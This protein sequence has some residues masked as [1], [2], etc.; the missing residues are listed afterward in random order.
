MYLKRVYIENNGAIE[1]VD[2][3]L[4]FTNQGAPKPVVL[5]GLNGSGK[6]NFLS[7][8]VDALFEGSA[9]YHRDI[10]PQDG[11]RRSFFRVAGGPNTRT[12]TRGSFTVLKFEHNGQEFMFREKVILDETDNYLANL[13]S[14]LSGLENWHVDGAHKEFS[15]SEV[16]AKNIFESN[17]HLYFPADRSEIPYWMN[18]SAVDEQWIHTT[19]TA[20]GYLKNPIYVNKSLDKLSQWIL[21]LIIDSRGGAYKNALGVVTVDEWNYK[22]IIEPSNNILRICDEILKLIMDDDEV[23]FAYGSRN[24][25]YKLCVAKNKQRFLASIQSLSAGQS[26]LL[27]IFGTLV[28]QH[29]QSNNE[30]GLDIDKVTGICIIDEADVNLH[31]DLQ[32]NVLPK[33]MSLFPN[34]Q[35]II[36]THSP[37]ILTGLNKLYGEDGL[38]IIDMPSGTEIGVDAY[39]EFTNALNV[40]KNTRKFEYLLLERMR[41]AS[42]PIVFVEGE[43]DEFYLNKACEFLGR[44]D[45]LSKC[46]IEWIGRNSE[47][48]AENTGATA[49]ENL[50]KFLKAKKDIIR[51]PILLL[52]DNDQKKSHGNYPG[53]S[54]RKVKSNPDNEIVK[55]GIENLLS[56]NKEFVDGYFIKKPFDNGNGRRG[57]HENL[58]KM[59]LCKHLIDEGS[60]EI[61]DKFHLVYDEIEDFLRE[62]TSGDPQG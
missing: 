1:R 8:I 51:E 49:L 13:P 44:A 45:I 25:P 22:N 58:D 46:R 17:L 5:V 59:A 62:F 16:D 20:A 52:Y 57:T 4:Q 50:E 23:Q 36:S 29:D 60:A 41:S 19:P 54:V 35:F 43:T 27:S 47:Q 37:L 15:I 14:D 10:L 6:T 3:K 32:S 11:M 61:F 12:G 42:I 9:K 24:D 7:I 2:L 48:G 34:I 21:S 38:Q 31:I 40:F 33:L 28:R 56:V 39:S 30:Y 53:Y 55:N 18:K 26:T